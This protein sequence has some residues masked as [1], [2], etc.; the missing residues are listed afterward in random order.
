MHLGEPLSGER[1]AFV[2]PID[3][4]FESEDGI[5]ISTIEEAR[6]LSSMM[7]ME[8]AGSAVM[9]EISDAEIQKN[10]LFIHAP[11]WNKRAAA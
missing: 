7:R 4:L 9:A 11:P 6:G 8:A 10:K 3:P 1:V 5:S 2:T